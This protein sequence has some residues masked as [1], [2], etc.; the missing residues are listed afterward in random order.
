MDFYR[1]TKH[2]TRS[3]LKD[4]TF[5]VTAFLTLAVCI[6]VNAAIFAIVNSVLLRPLPVADANAILL[7]SN[8]YPKAGAPDTHNSSA[9][10]YYD[11]RT[12]VSALPEQAMFRFSDQTV[13]T[14][15]SA[16]QVSGMMVTPT[17]FPLLRVQP[18]LGRNFTDAEGEVGAEQEVILSYGMWQEQFGGDRSVAGRTVRLGGRPFTVV[19]VMPR[20]F[21]FVDPEV[22][23]W[24][25]LAFT[26]EQKTTHHSNN[27]YH[28]GRLKPGATIQ[29]VRAQIDALNAANLE[30]F[31][32]IKQLLMN[33]GFHTKV[34]PLQEMLVR[35]VKGILYLLWGGALFVMLIGALNVTN[36]ALA[37]M[38][39]RHREFGTRLALGAQRVHLARQVILEN[40]LLA[41]T[42]GVAGLALGWGL[43][44]GLS[45][46][47]LNHF[48]RASE[49]GVNFQTV[50]FVLAMAAASGVLIAVMPLAAVLKSSLRSVLTEHER[51]GT[52]SKGARRVRQAMVVGQISL[53]FALLAGAGL[54]LASFRQLLKTDPGFT[55][56][57]VVTASTNLPRAR[58]PKDEQTR[59]LLDRSLAAIRQL[60]GVISAGATD[61]IPFSNSHSDGVILAEGY[62]MK[63][64]ESII[65]PRQLTVAP[66]YFETMR[67]ALRY[68]RYFED[69]DNATA[70]GAVIVDERL[71]QRFWPDRDPVGRRMYRPSD[72]KDLL[73]IDEHTHWLQVI[74]VVRSVHLDDLTDSG[75]PVGAY[76]FP[77]AQDSN[78]RGFTVAVRT[79]GDLNATARDIR[80]TMAGIDPELA[81]FDIKTMTE[82]A[83]LSLANRRM[84][85]TLAGVFGILALFLA[86]VGIYGVL[87]YLVTQRRR[88]IGIR[89]ALGST[90]G[91]IVKLV[92][93]EGLV[94]V[95][96]GLALGIAC[97]A[98]LRT[99]IA[100]QIYGVH[101]L[102]PLVMGSV[103]V[104]LGLV[105]MAACAVPA[106]RAMKVDPVI[107]LNEQQ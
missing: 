99:A 88:E 7:M 50:V 107:V 69:R 29:Q 20:N 72:A 19:G 60:P 87:S 81:L 24:T 59:A 33:A 4:R 105:A 103:I 100:G 65:S 46:L 17:L 64:G 5:A 27:W 92:L 71:A 48:P 67:V 43:L 28:I 53:A 1:Q 41:V 52:G 11:R 104:L 61:D 37:R 15:N 70:P 98:A 35:D 84:S 40:V 74:G 54:L 97:A 94:L 63:P 23:L 51:S 12:A 66:G 8:G 47:G 32:E 91:R 106:R 2:A 85:L 25:P 57:G 13:T 82:R 58:Y 56:T 21:V 86:A 3:L 26:P 16:Q 31:P 30:R 14:A 62:Q 42:S 79:A 39:L 45:R 83:D 6:A 80:K 93:R 101:A 38:G 36:L 73:K 90:Q 49:V 102:D 76:Y 34:E 55:M 75:S 77:F 95:A 89:M 18:V 44:R 22:R 10:D 78:V 96:I 9:G 68:G